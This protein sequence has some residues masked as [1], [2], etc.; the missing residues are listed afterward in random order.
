MQQPASASDPKL[1]AIIA[2]I[3]SPQVIASESAVK[4]ALKSLKSGRATTPGQLTIAPWLGSPNGTTEEFLFIQSLDAGGRRNAR[5]SNLDTSLLDA[6]LTYGETVLTVYRQILSH[7]TQLAACEREYTHSL[8]V[9]NNLA[10][11][12]KV[13][14]AQVAAGT[15]P[16]S[17]VELAKVIWNEAHIAAVMASDRVAASRI[18]LAAY[19][20]A[21]DIQE[22]G[23]SERAIPNLSHLQP[24]NNLEQ[25]ALLN[26]AKLSSELRMTSAASRPDVSMVV[27][28][29]N[30][31]RNFTPNDR[32]V[33]LQLS[34]PVDHGSIKSSKAT[35]A[36]QISNIE[37]RIKDDQAKQSSYRK[38][39]EATI[40]SID[41]AIATTQQTVVLPMT[42][43]VAKM[44]RAYMAGT[45]TVMAYLDAQRSLHAAERKLI[46]LKDQRD[47]SILQLIEQGGMAPSQLSITIKQSDRK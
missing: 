19:G 32:G 18:N 9:E 38:A 17:D 36:S 43:Y 46:T 21:S 27:R 35:I 31:T 34:I 33:A 22:S 44:Q 30:F 4:S 3:R 1:I 29:Q 37:L 13:I 39:I 2:T 15:K 20:I 7:L 40:S 6:Q 11:S 16:G 8:Q 47:Q 25:R 26:V 42:D 12:L 41:A 14:E 23:V 28:S 24:T 10:A 45:V 5:L